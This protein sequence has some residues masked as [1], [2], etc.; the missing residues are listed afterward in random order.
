MQPDFPTPQWNHHPRRRRYESFIAMNRETV[1]EAY[2]LRYRVFAGELGARLKGQDLD[3]DGFDPF[4]DHLVVR[5][6]QSGRVVAT[7]RLLSDQA[8][9]RAGGFYSEQEFDLGAVGDQLGRLL[10]VGRTCIDPAC[11]G[12]AVLTILWSG[13]ARYAIERGFEYLIGCASIPPGPQG[14]TVEA[15]CNRLEPEQI[16]PQWL[17]VTSLRPVPP[18]LRTQRDVCGI[19]PLLQTYLRLG[20]WVCGDPFWDEDFN[21]MDVFILL[22]LVR[23][24]TRYARRFLGQ[25]PTHHELA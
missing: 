7:T 16:G 10:E 22:P 24:N 25:H 2:R 11:R 20:A 19:P 8:A 4:C 6:H 15:F 5:D 3:Q 13:L 14:F 1:E 18:E 12:T 9:I 17:N 21:C 23:L